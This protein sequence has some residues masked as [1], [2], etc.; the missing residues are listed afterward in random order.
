MVDYNFYK[1]KRVLVIGDTGFKGSWLSVWLN[2]LGAD[3][4]G[5]ALDTT[6][7]PSHFETAGLSEILEDHRLDIRDGEAPDLS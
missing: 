3:V 4:I 1:N 7:Q 6:S 5:F 2:L